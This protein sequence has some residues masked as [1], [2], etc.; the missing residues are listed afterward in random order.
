MT[1][2]VR[3]RL[4]VRLTAIGVCAA[5]ALFIGLKV[6]F[7]LEARL[8]VAVEEQMR[9]AEVQSEMTFKVKR[10]FEKRWKD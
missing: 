2:P 4:W 6:I 3:T 8:T 10:I 5:V 9:A 1:D 7:A